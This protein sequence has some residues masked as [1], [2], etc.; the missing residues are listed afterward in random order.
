VSELKL[1]RYR[2][3]DQAD[4]FELHVLGLKQMDAYGGDGP[5]DD[6]LRHIIEH[7]YHNEGEFLVGKYEGR[8]VA[9]GA[10]RKTGDKEAEIKRM[11]THPDFQGRG[12]GQQIY[13]ALEAKAREMGY[14]RLHLE[15]GIKQIPA[16]RFY[17]RNGYIKTHQGTVHLGIAS[18]FYEKYL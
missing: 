7:Y 8:L 13:E 15:T 18:F 6:D 10:F 14:T 17:T 4:V 9:M 5:W 3:S 12:F 2:E 11:R 16:Q 1:C